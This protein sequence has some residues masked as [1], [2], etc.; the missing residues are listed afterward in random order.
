MLGRVA[1]EQGAVVAADVDHEVAGLQAREL[2]GGARDAVQV[3]GHRP[4]DA[5][6]VPVGLVEDRAGHRVAGLDQPARVLVARHVA[7]DE[8]E[9]DGALHRLAPPGS[10]NAPAMH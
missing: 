8:L 2:L 10:A 3:L 4:V 9:R 5:A 7:A 6:A 1:V